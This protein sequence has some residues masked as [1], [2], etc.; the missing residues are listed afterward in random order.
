V[1]DFA[2]ALMAAGRYDPLN[3]QINRLQ[4]ANTNAMNAAQGL[5]YDMA[6]WE[7][8][9]RL[10]QQHA[11]ED[12]YQ[13]ALRDQLMDYPIGRPATY[14]PPVPQPEPMLNPVLLLLE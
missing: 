2:A 7:S 8:M 9:A 14:S 5:G 10:R 3:D 13:Q 1:I 12:R 4:Q 11:K 6:P